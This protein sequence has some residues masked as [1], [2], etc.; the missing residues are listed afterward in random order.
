MK[1]TSQIGSLTWFDDLGYGFDSTA[2]IEYSGDYL[3]EYERRDATEI[4]HKITQKRCELVRRHT[5]RQPVDIGIGAGAFVKA[6][7]CQGYDINQIAVK[8]LKENGKF[9]DPYQSFPGCLT[10]WDSLEHIPDPTELLRR[11][12]V[13]GLVFCS[14]PVFDGPEQCVNSKHYKPGEH[15]WYWS[16][17]GFLEY[18][19]KQKFFCLE[20]NNCE[21][22]LGRDSVKSYAFVKR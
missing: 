19:A 15:I 6:M 20:W 7:E 5:T 13:G 1:K 22:M 9:I 16:H 8:W 18:M 14:I 12:P 10:F 21:T 11:I 4:G 17:E 3:A 2:P